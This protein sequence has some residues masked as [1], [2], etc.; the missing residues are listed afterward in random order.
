MFNELINVF[1]G[2]SFFFPIC[3]VISALRNRG[4]LAF[5]IPLLLIASL[6]F[7]PLLLTASLQ[8]ISQGDQIV[9]RGVVWDKIT[10]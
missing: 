4:S 10:V 5:N 8:N 6:T 2:Q 3:L 1:N 7:Q 9:Q